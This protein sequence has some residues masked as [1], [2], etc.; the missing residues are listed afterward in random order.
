MLITVV[1]NDKKQ[2]KWKLNKERTN[3]WQDTDVKQYKD[4]LEKSDW[5]AWN[6][7]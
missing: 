3:T 7:F 1:Y 5:L 6:L 4:I 2:G